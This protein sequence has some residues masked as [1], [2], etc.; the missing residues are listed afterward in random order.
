M[1]SQA[2]KLYNETEKKETLLK[3][4]RQFLDDKQKE[5]DVG[6]EQLKDARRA[7]KMVKKELGVK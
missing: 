3:A 2:E 7:L 4:D 5:I 1:L 6:F